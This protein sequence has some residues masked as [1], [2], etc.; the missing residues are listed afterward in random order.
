MKKFTFSL[1]KVLQLRKYREEECKLALGQAISILNMIENQIKENAV[2]HY[3]AASERFKEPEQIVSWDVYILRLE[4]EAQNLTEKAAQAEL[5]VEEKRAEY[6][7]ASKDLKAMEKLKEKR[8]MEYR[9][10]I[11]DYQMAEIDELTAARW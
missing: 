9:K 4:H 1:Q 10:E 7:E 3:H 6:L 8:Q 11:S 5:V 2:K